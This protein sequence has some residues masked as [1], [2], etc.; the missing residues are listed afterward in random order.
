MRHMEEEARVFAEEDGTGWYI[1]DHEYL[2]DVFW[3]E[4]FEPAVLRGD[5]EI[6]VRCLGV[7]DEMLA[8]PDMELRDSVH[9]FLLRRLRDDSAKSPHVAGWVRSRLG[10]TD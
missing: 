3:D 9:H 5:D 4:V 2:I 7:V 10:L 6:V 8:G 1:T